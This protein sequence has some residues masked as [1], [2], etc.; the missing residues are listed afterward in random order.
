MLKHI[1]MKNFIGRF[2]VC[3]F[4]ILGLAVACTESGKN[5]EEVQFSVYDESGETP[6]SVDFEAKGKNGY[7]LRVMSNAQWSL[8]IK[9]GSDWI[10]ASP[11]S[12]EKGARQ[13]KVNIAKNETLEARTGG[14]VFTCK[15]K[16]VSIVITQKKGSKEGEI[17]VPPTPSD[18]P[19]ADLLDVI[20]KNDGTAVDNS[21]SKMTITAVSGSAS[22]NY[23]SD[24]YSRYAAHF[25][26]TLGSAMSA[27][28][29]K[30]DYT[31]D[32]KFRNALADGHS[33]E[34]VFR[35][36][37][38]ANGSEIKPFSSMQ[39]G[40]TGFLITDNSRGKDITFLP[41]VSANGKSS[42]KWTHSN[43]TPEVGRYYHVVGVWSK[44]AGKSYIYVNGELKGETEAAGSLNFPTEG[45]TWFCVGGDPNGASGAHCGFNGDVVIARIYDDVLTAKDVAELYKVVKNDIKPEVI[46]IS[47]LT[48]LPNAN[49]KPGCW[50]Y[51]YAK[52]FK[53][54]DRIKLESMSSESLS[55]S[56][57]TADGDG[58]LKIRIPD[59]FRA[60]KYRLVLGRGET[61]YPLGSSE[62][63]VV[64]DLKNLYNTKIV[65]HRGY[66]YGNAA[67]NSVASLAE[68]QK[69]GVYG[70]EFDVYITTDGVPVIYH[71]S[72][73]K[74]DEVPE[75][76]KY[77]GW[78][79]DSRTYEEIKD[80]KLANGEPL[81]TLDD[82][83]N[84]AKLY[85]N[86]KL[87][88]EI[89]NHNTTDKTMRAAQTCVDAVKAKGLQ[90]QV[91]YIAFSYDVCKKLAGLAPEATVQYLNGDKA[92]STVFA[93]GI[94]GIDY[95][96]SKLTDA[97]IKEA[98]GLGMTVNVWTV[99]NVSDML[100]FIAKG[101]SLITT[102]KPV[103]GLELLSKPF[104]TEE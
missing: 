73:F 52:G 50:F 74:G 96:Y 90:N 28:Y 12:G 4:A 71:N 92:P 99:N 23:F 56:C 43:I 41:N 13:V 49:V 29:Y 100:N 93:D 2:C 26:H 21:D 18:V 10:A 3:V 36:D 67:E 104:V 53:G 98:N 85:P 37:A 83:L 42:W 79:P 34:V 7:S 69:L 80:Y 65:A 62:F 84:Q 17:V 61:Q 66:H 60:G 70:S 63:N 101:V 51:V 5:E 97:W 22:V 40:G 45:S 6:K 48:L 14:L 8:E 20:F 30:I 35:M 76:A 16:S 46:S 27:G 87:I 9:D 95:S 47:D 19:E 55:Y 1:I 86:V 64:S 33:M 102:D 94:K 32:Q 59:D 57:T 89:K 38:P 58:F 54:G 82:Y 44:Q 72:T 88:I 11:L 15:T 68:A 103:E 78:R 31:Q 39:S 77:K 91:E 25:N 75:D 24:A 81:P